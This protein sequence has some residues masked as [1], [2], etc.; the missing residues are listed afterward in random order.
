MLY[1]DMALVYASDESGESVMSRVTLIFAAAAAMGLVL[2]GCSDST[3]SLPEWLASKPS[4]P[5]LQ[6]LHFQSEPPGANVR[7]D[8]GQ[9]CQTPC[10]LVVSPESQSV[11]IEKDGFTAQTVQVAVAERA[12]HSIFSKAPPPA[13]SPNPVDV[14]LQ[15]EPK[16]APKKP[17]AHKA[18]V[19]A[20]HRQ[21]ANAPARKP[22]G[23]KP[24]HQ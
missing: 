1:Q 5:P 6:T 17:A 16:P 15:A 18:A 24:P 21:A 14:A 10:S 20:S 13:L 8:K 19:H 12:E 11:T 22:E 2:A 7:T 4:A 9:T 23:P 3:S